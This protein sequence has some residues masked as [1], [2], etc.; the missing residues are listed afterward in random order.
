MNN[1]NYYYSSSDN[2]LKTINTDGY[3]VV[4]NILNNDE[5]E[6]AKNGLWNT[7]NYLTSNCN[8]PI[9]KK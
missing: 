3:C 2:I 1:Y 9:D 7:M 5:I 8:K 4:K 6:S